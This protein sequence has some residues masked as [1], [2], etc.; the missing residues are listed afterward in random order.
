LNN[1]N[2]QFISKTITEYNDGRRMSKYD[3]TKFCAGVQL[4]SHKN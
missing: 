1:P 4:F 3:I 2:P